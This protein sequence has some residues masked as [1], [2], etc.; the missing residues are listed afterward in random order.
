MRMDRVGTICLTLVLVATGTTRPHA[1]AA[2]SGDTIVVQ[3]NY[4]LLQAVTNTRFAPMLTARALAITHTCIYDAWAAYDAVA[5]GVYWP[6]DLRQP[7][8]EQTQA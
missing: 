4:A 7:P 8:G 6:T 1:Q 2:P 5:D 3:W